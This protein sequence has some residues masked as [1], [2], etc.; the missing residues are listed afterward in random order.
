MAIL[1]RKSDG[2]CVPVPSPCLLGR[3]SA[4]ALRL[5]EPHVSSEHARLKWRASSWTVRDLGSRNGTYVGGKR[6][7]SGATRELAKGDE[8][9]FGSLES[10]W[11]LE[12]VSPP[13]PIAR[14]LATSA[15]RG[16]T[17]GMLALPSDTLPAA[18]VLEDGEGR[19]VVEIDG[20]ARPAEDGAL[21]DVAGERWALHLPAPGVSTWEAGDPP[22]A[23]ATGELRLSV[24][25]DEEQVEVALVAGGRAHAM[26]PRAH[27]YLL[28]TLARARIQAEEDAVLLPHERGWTSV[29]AL[30]RMLGI[31]E[32]K[33][34][35]EVYRVRRDLAELGVVDAPAIIERRR[36]LRTLRLGIARATIVTLP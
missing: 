2:L 24:S 4:V 33:L 30:T 18:V 14:H 9:A 1:R 31:E 28:L 16:A 23:L 20:E 5:E 10:A 36:G 12:D 34:N 13:G 7:D 17:A 11:I 3:S 29:D 35:V 15:L 19:Y 32:I 26:P 8:L 22:L 6:L 25:R 27:Y 21:L